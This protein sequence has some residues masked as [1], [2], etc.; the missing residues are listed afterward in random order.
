MTYLF[1][2]NATIS[3]EVEV[4]NDAGNALPI[5]KNTFTNSA[6]NPI[7]TTGTVD[8]I[9]GGTYSKFRQYQ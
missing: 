5:S 6:T 7:Y 2:S 9:P 3:N 8:V 4:K 1:T